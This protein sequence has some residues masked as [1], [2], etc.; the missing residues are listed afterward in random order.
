MEEKNLIGKV[1]KI[2][3]LVGSHMIWV[4][5][6]R[7]V[8]TTASDIRNCVIGNIRQ[9]D[10]VRKDMKQFKEFI[11]S[12]NISNHIR[13]QSTNFSVVSRP[14][15]LYW[16]Y[17]RSDCTV[18]RSDFKLIQWWN[19][20]KSKLPKF[21]TKINGL[22]DKLADLRPFTDDLNKKQNQLR[23]NIIDLNRTLQESL[24]K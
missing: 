19:C 3:H 11:E 8:C 13:V 15:R 17:F 23:I 2:H 6:W 21:E 1:I 18:Q 7:L 5:L 10:K 22:A 14:V 4:T 20:E 9:M 16:H 24:V 12:R